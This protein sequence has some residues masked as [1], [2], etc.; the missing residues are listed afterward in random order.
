[1]KKPRILAAVLA[2]FSLLAVAAVAADPSGTWKWSVTGPD[3]SSFETTLTLALKD[4]KLTGTYSNQFG[5]SQISGAT[6]K[7]DAIAF[8]VDRE[9]NGNKFV[10]KYQGKLVG[11]TIKGMI[12]LPG[13]GDGESRKLDWNAQRGK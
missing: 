2:A 12:E 6:F 11:D 4:G 5:D 7:G 9:F 13:M 3:G 1:M 8:Q 10:I